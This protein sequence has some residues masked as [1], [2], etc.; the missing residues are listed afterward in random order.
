M[1]A[2]LERHYSMLKEWFNSGKGVRFWSRLAEVRRQH[3]DFRQ[4]VAKHGKA[5]IEPF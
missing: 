1:L 5:G 3:P 2:S 4:R